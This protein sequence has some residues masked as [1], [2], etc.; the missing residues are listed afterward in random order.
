M[1]GS[2]ANWK[3]SLNPK[4]LEAVTAGDGPIL[5]IAGAGTGKTWTLACRVAHLIEQGVPPER[6]L[7]LTF[8]RRAAKEMLTR[9]DRLNQGKGTGKVW[10]GTFHAI[11]N[12]LLRLYGRP[13]GLSPDFTVL[14]QADMA[15]LIDLVR[16]EQ[17]PTKDKRERRFPRKDTL[18]AIYSRMVNAGQ[19]LSAVLEEA[20]PWCAD[21][22][23]GIRAIFAEYTRRKRAQNILDYDDLLLF[24]RAL[25]PT[26]AGQE[27]ARQFEHVLVDEYQDTNPLQA[28]ILQSL[29]AE[30]RN[31]RKRSTGSVLP[32]SATSSIFRST[33]PAR[34][35]SPSNRTTAPLARFWMCPMR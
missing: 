11:A 25:G 9:A 26:P 4:Q 33:F 24:W 21:E 16:G 23:D 15:D 32:P 17:H 6:I 10:G 27:A 2:A 30:N 3:A 7:L 22:A 12:R 20:F 18:V 31:L 1:F 35:A 19:P 34:G 28:N 14:D 8:S 29:R 5:V 13:L